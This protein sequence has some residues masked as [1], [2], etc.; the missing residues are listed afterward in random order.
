MEIVFA[1]FIPN[2]WLLSGLSRCLIS[3]SPTT[4]WEAPSSK[5]G[6]WSAQNV[7]RSLAIELFMTVLT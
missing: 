3:V 2:M 5:S 7:A 6:S 1:A 4:L